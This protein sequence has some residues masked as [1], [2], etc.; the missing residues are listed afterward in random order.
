MALPSHL[1]VPPICQEDD[2]SCVPFCILM[3]LEYI[4][5]QNA[6]NYIPPITIEKISQVIGTDIDGTP[7]DNIEAINKELEKAVPSIE[8][9]TA[10]NCSINELEA[11]I[12]NGKPVIAWVRMP[13]PHSIVVTGLDRR[14]LVIYLNDPEVGETQIEMGRFSS[15]WN[16]MGNILIKVKIGEKIQRIIPEYAEDLAEERGA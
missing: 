15:G 16:E 4:R 2:Y 8:F 13:Y 12:L 14:A 5:T 11:E 3:I 1:E 9:V 6:R 10:E 7:L